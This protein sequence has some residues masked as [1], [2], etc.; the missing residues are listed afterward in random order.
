MTIPPNFHNP[1][2]GYTPENNSI[3]TETTLNDPGECKNLKT[4]KF[5]KKSRK[6]DKTTLR[7]EKEKFRATIVQNNKPR[8]IVQSIMRK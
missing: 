1:I 3:N 5:Q 4:G 7:M 8:H 2:D 6:V